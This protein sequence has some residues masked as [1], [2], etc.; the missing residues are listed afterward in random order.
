MVILNE[1]HHA[2][3]CVHLG[4]RGTPTRR[5]GRI[6]VRHVDSAAHI[7]ELSDRYFVEVRSCLV[8]REVRDEG[9]RF[10]EFSF[11]NQFSSGHRDDR[12]C[13]GV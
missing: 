11:L 1:V 10:A 4:D 5:S 8:L 2:G 13:N 9:I 12:F 3:G 7:D 6:I